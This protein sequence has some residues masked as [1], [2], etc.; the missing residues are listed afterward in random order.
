MGGGGGG[1]GGGGDGT[2]MAGVSAARGP[3]ALPPVTV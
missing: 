1:G 3:K 2:L